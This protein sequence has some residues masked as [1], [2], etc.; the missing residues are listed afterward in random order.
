MRILS[1]MVSVWLA[2]CAVPALAAEGYANCV[3]A[4]DPS[5]CIARRAM[6]SPGLRAWST[7]EAALRHGLVDLVPAKADMLFRALYFKVGDPETKVDS[8]YAPILNAEPYGAMR[9][10]A[11]PPMLAAMALAAAARHETNPFANAIYRELAHQAQDDPRI[12]VL[13]MALWLEF[14]GRYAAPPDRRASY[15]GLPAIWGRAVARRAE[16]AE[17]LA[18]IAGTESFVENFRPQAKAFFAWYA[19]R[20]DLTPDQRVTT[21]SRLARLLDMPEQAA[22]LLEGLAVDVPG[23]ELPGARSAIA[24]ARLAKRYDA[25]SA[26]QLM[27]IF[28]TRFD[29]AEI[30]L[31]ELES[32]GMGGALEHSGARKELLELAAEY[33]RQAERGGGHRESAQLYAGASDLYLRAGDLKRAREIARRGLALM[34]ASVAYAASGFTGRHVK[35]APRE[36]ALA[37]HDWGTAPVIALYR[38][39]AIEEALDTGYLTGY[40]RFRHA[41]RAGERPDPQW[42]L[43]DKDAIS[44]AFMADDVARGGDRDIQQRAYEGLVISCGKPLTEC[45]LETL[46]QIAEVAAGRG[47]ESGMKEALAAAARQLDAAPDDEF[48][49]LYVAGT[50]AHCE[51]VLSR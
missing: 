43:D 20:K 37:A 40:S 3:K 17:L 24:L 1:W 25:E 12:P 6:A 7:L 33:V 19:Q 2:W 31:E 36:M 30:T 48:P 29:I 8:A 50:W 13:A 47:D 21:A 18:N 14:D 27:Y 11:R 15:A 46:Q 23:W 32:S 22:S 39:G 4:T 51:A 5:G 10:S 28:F 16:D 38:T 34:P 41:R 35:M 44:I 42:V 49:A 9:T 26:R 45:S